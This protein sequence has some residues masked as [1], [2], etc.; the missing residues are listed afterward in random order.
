MEIKGYITNLGKYNEGD[1]VGKWVT[2]PIDED[3]LNEVLHEI[4]CCY[5]D[6]EGEYI[7]TGYEEYFFTDW[8]G[9]YTDLG[10]YVNIETVNELAEKLQTWEDDAEKF[11]AACDVWGFKYVIE[12]SPDDYILYTEI[13]DNYDLGY[14]WAVESGCYDLGKMG[15]LANYIDYESFGR[16][17]GFDVDGGHT[18]QG[19]IE[20]VG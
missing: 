5:Y 15:A 19:F 16:D 17:I 14:Y 6:E 2:F 11:E 13:Q 7:N 1:L 8:D 18:S 20:Y 9:S 10:E 4:G 12:N 3:E